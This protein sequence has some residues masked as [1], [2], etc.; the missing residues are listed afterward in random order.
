M[1]V[2]LGVVIISSLPYLH[3]IITVRG[4]GLKNWVP[5]FGIKEYLTD[6]QGY[7]A[8]FSSYRVFI[9]TLSIHLFAHIGWVGFFYVAKTKPYR[10]F[11]LVPVTLSLYQVFIILFNYRSTKFND[12]NTKIIITLIISICLILNFFLNNKTTKHE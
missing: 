7:I 6:S 10:F 3:D 9:Y 4:E 8:G 12:V 2:A 1:K 11:I 5:N